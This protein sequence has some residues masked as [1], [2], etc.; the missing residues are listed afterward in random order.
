MAHRGVP[1]KTEPAGVS[2]LGIGEPHRALQRRW[3]CRGRSRDASGRKLLCPGLQHS[4]F[5]KTPPWGLWEEPPRMTALL[6]CRQCLA[7]LPTALAPPAPAAALLP[8]V[9]CTV[10]TLCV[11][12][13]SGTA[14]T[15]DPVTLVPK[16]RHILGS[17]LPRKHLV[18]S[19]IRLLGH[20]VPT[21]CDQR[22]HLHTSPLHVLFELAGSTCEDF[23]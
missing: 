14:L 2:V 11:V 12:L 3:C 10:P 1:Q 20:S 7:C 4:L 21:P 13:P 9:S 5:L 8:S 22:Q 15:Q 6:G 16:L 17:L 23:T 18:P 19:L